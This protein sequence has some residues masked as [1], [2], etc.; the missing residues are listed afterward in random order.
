MYPRVSDQVDI[1]RRRGEIGSTAGARTGAWQHFRQ[2]TRRPHIATT[3]LM[4]VAGRTNS[5]GRDHGKALFFRGF[6]GLRGTIGG[7]GQ[8]DEGAGGRPVGT[9]RRFAVMG[10][11]D[12]AD[13]GWKMSG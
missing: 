2:T 11:Y 8:S 1:A 10:P 3:G 4:R 6:P 7:Y 12:K 5:P 9:A 13:C